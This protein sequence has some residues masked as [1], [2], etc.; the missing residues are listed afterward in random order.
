MAAV[1]VLVLLFV[2]SG[3]ARDV[4]LSTDV[5]ATGALC[6]TIS[7]AGYAAGWGSARVLHFRSDV[8]TAVVFTTGMREFGVAAAIVTAVMPAAA[9]VVGTYGI[10]ILVTAPVLVR[11]IQR[12]EGQHRNFFSHTLPTRPSPR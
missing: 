1:T 9:A 2:V 10:T 8:T 6:L 11:F 4:I 12:V 7:V 3:S 5:F